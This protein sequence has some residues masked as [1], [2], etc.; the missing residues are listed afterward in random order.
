MLLNLIIFGFIFLV[1]KMGDLFSCCSS[2]D[3]VEPSSPD[4][5]VCI[6]YIIIIIGYSAKYR[7][8]ARKYIAKMQNVMSA[9]L[10]T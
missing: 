4:A 10:Y 9:V 6:Y 1:F 3:R 5:K 2:S 8:K 7:H